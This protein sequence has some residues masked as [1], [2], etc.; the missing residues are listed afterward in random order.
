VGKV[1]AGIAIKK[2]EEIMYYPNFALLLLIN[3]HQ[4]VLLL[5]RINT[6]FCNN[7][8]SLP[9]GKIE[10]GETP[11]D[12]LQREAY[13]SLGIN[14]SAR[15]QFKFVHCM[16]RKCNE[17]EFFACVFQL[18]KWDG[19]PVNKEIDRHDD[20]QWFAVN[21]L[22]ENIVPAHRQA[23]ELIMQ[24]SMYSEHGWNTKSQ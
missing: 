15:E 8:Y 21:K 14:I 9:G 17:P 13:N 23:I 19:V 4:E 24:G 3:M 10:R 6:P 5:R 16:Y 2:C 22:P 1:T 20:I 7:C 11:F 18:L 12:M